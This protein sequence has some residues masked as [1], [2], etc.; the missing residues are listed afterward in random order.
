MGD[1][2]NLSLHS[3]GRWLATIDDAEGIAHEAWGA[4]PLDAVALLVEDMTT[5]K[6]VEG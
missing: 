4:T 2:V 3:S 1:A 5:M 6:T